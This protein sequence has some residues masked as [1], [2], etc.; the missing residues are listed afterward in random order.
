VTMFVFVIL[1]LNFASAFKGDFVFK[2]GPAPFPA[3]LRAAALAA[4]YEWGL[5]Q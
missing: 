3:G 4:D 5:W 2:G 1:S